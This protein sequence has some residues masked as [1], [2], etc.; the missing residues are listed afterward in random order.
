M[1]QSIKEYKT[2]GH[3]GFC[4]HEFEASLEKNNLQTPAIEKKKKT[5]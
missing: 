3:F 4:S 1:D 2:V 5:E